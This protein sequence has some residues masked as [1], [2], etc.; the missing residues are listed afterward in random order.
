[1]LFCTI[2]RV[3][4]IRDVATALLAG[5]VFQKQ[6]KPSTD[7]TRCAGPMETGEKR[8][9]AG[10]PGD[11]FALRQPKFEIITP[12]AV[13]PDRILTSMTTQTAQLAP[14]IRMAGVAR[15][16]SPRTPRTRGGPLP[17]ES[18]IYSEDGEGSD[19]SPSLSSNPDQEAPS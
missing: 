1:M 2:R 11:Y 5:R 16:N 14:T 18:S 10:L 9:S 7:T 12:P 3:I 17:R 6:E 15:A 4:P 19:R 8:T 13:L